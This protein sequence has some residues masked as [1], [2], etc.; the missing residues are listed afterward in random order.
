MTPSKGKAKR[1][2]EASPILKAQRIASGLSIEELSKRSNISDRSIGKAEDGKRVLYETVKPLIED[3]N[4]PEELAFTY[5]SIRGNKYVGEIDLIPEGLFV[6]D[7]TQYHLASRPISEG[8]A[9]KL[10][11]ENPN[12]S[13]FS[14]TANDPTYECFSILDT[15]VESLEDSKIDNSNHVQDGLAIESRQY[16][17]SPISLKD[18]IELKNKESIVKRSLE[19]LR[20]EG[21][22]IYHSTL[23]IGWIWSHPDDDYPSSESEGITQLFFIDHQDLNFVF[24]LVSGTDPEAVNTFD[25]LLRYRKRS[26][27]EVANTYD[28]SGIGFNCPNGLWE[29]GEEEI[30]F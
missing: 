2:V 24:S 28:P 11:V 12:S 4:I 7:M 8:E 29:L 5:D 16:D 13:H 17:I 26:L 19:K 9:A 23:Y 3:L 6:R 1:Y 20:E 25:S 14:L 30:P 18:A 22:R 10:I 27:D 15:I 21:L